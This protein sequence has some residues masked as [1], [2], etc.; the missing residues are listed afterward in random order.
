MR[1]DARG[2]F[3]SSPPPPPP[4]PSRCHHSAQKQCSLSPASV[5]VPPTSTDIHK[6]K[7]LLRHRLCVK[8]PS[9][10]NFSE[11][12]RSVSKS[13]LECRAQRAWAITAPKA[14]YKDEPGYFSLD[15]RLVVMYAFALHRAD[16]RIANLTSTASPTRFFYLYDC[17][18]PPPATTPARI[19]NDWEMVKHLFVVQSTI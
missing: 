7:I 5:H 2:P 4:P 9:W 10:K 1:T 17:V 14:K 12:L 16:S 18:R 3:T 6:H 13:A 19:Q 11:N 15:G 8:K